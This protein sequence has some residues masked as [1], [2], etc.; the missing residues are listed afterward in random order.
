MAKQ[1]GLGDRLFAGGVNLSGDIGSVDKVSGGPAALEQTGIDKEAFERIGG[2]REAGIDYAA[3]WNPTGAHPVLSALPTGDQVVTYCR[4]FG[5][6]APAAGLVAK[7]VNYDGKRGTDGSLGL[8]VS[9]VG[10]A[11]SPLEWGVQGTDGI[12]TDTTATNGASLDNGVAVGSTAFGLAAYLHVFAL[13]GTSVTVKL[14][15]SNDNG[16]G[17]AWADVTGG[18]FTAAAGVGA[19]RIATSPTLTI[20]RY[21]RV[22]TTGTFTNAQLH[23]LVARNLLAG[24]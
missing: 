9:T 7:Q 18:G 24:P 19:Q 3:W 8:T 17:D 10:S 2:L 11:G 5:L 12:R 22:V 15:H 23:V 20:K 4:G 1:S 14:Q 21:L 16:V 13:T 6:G